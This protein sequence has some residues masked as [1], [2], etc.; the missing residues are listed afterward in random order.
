[1]T[2]FE[3]KQFENEEE[4]RA[5]EVISEENPDAKELLDEENFEG[6]KK[7]AYVANQKAV[8]LVKNHDDVLPMVK[9]GNPMSE[10]ILK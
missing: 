3:D 7:A 9:G 6:A 4:N 10:M 2:D 1:M 8:V 5:E